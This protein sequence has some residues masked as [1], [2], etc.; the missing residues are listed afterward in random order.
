MHYRIF[1]DPAGGTRLKDLPLIGKRARK[2]TAISANSTRRMTRAGLGLALLLGVGSIAARAQFGS[3]PT[4]D[5][6]AS[7][8]TAVQGTAQAQDYS[9]QQNYGQND[10]Y[11]QNGASAGYN[12][13]ATGQL[14]GQNG[15]Q[16]LNDGLSVDRNGNA[17]TNRQN[18]ANVPLRRVAPEPPTQFQRVIT[19][20][21]GQTAP[22]FGADMFRSVPSTFA[23]VDNIPVTPEYVIG[24]GDEVRLQAWGQVNLRG[25]YTVD[26][27]GSI[28]VPNVGTLH[29]AGL[30]YS[31]LSDFLRSH[32]AQVYR[33]FDLNVNLG[34]LRSI[35]VF[36]VG[37][38]RQPGSYTIGSLSTLLN[39]LFASGGPLPLG[40]L[41]DIQ[42]RRGGQTVVH[43]DLYDLVLHGDKTKDVALE[44]GDV[45]FVP[46]VGP[47]V[48]VLGS[49]KFPAVYE[50]NGEKTYQQVVALAGGETNV[51]AGS[52]ARV[53]RV[54]H[55]SERDVVSVDLQSAESPVVQDGD[56]LI[57]N[58]ILQRFRDSVTMRGNVANPGRYAWHPG[59][60]ISDLIPDQDSLVTRDYYL[61]QNRLGQATDYLGQGQESGVAASA[62]QN[63]D[64]NISQQPN[65]GVAAQTADAPFTGANVAAV[66]TTNATAVGQVQRASL[67]TGAGGVSAGSVLTQGSNTFQPKTDVMLSAPDIDWDYA[68]IERQDAKTLTTSLLPFNLGKVVLD[69]DQSQNLE[70]LPGDVVTVFSK[71]D[72]R[73]PSATQTKFVKLEGEFVGAG[74]YS[75]Q[76]GETLRHLLARAGGL[77]PDAYLY[78]S[79]F[80]RVSVQRLQ[81]QRLMEY[82][83]SLE[84]SI[85]TQTSAAMSSALSDRDAAAAQASADQARSELTRLRELQPSGRIVLQLKPDSRGIDAVPDIALEDGDRFVVP[86]T[87]T[88]VSV[89]GQ[90]YS[91][92]AF[93]FEPDRKVRD[94]LRM[95]GGPERMA[96]TSREYILRADGSVLSHQYTSA[97]HFGDFD[98][99]AMQPGD[100]II[101]PPKVQ[102]GN[103]LRD[104]ANIATILEGFGI[105]AAA[106]QVLR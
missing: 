91:A 48:A 31:Q 43:F 45:I 66:G 61:R 106:V 15:S 80:T 96:D 67:G 84:S 38:V 69:K 82:A 18:L 41:R 1:F 54:Y 76:P 87:P 71:A 5:D 88:S 59:M 25:S 62:S 17:L 9:N 101:V 10:A 58:S 33:N 8:P 100:T 19:E 97:R 85:S 35:Q 105:A 12:V 6:L 72:I 30:Q 40:S 103:A 102:K 90:V 78:G 36:V 28:L 24:P 11:G 49:V 46:E 75:V 26:R 3:V 60:R 27:T 104:A 39:A 23:P 81:K 95:A 83:D 74:V 22:I 98:H 89:V 53:E 47:Q 4:P 34:Q 32:L 52:G 65:S 29:V 51:A 73:V 77:T 94:Y 93:V 63:S 21:T 20:T 99:I 16:G 92:N 68:V 79:E 44:S 14:S 13:P 37:K 50:L 55:H 7:D 70:L 86:K 2:W 57:V 64:G 42:L 56:V